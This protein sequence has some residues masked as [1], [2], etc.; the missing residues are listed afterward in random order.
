MSKGSST[1]RHPRLRLKC[2]RNSGLV[3]ATLQ[4]GGLVSLGTLAVKGCGFAKQTNQFPLRSGSTYSGFLKP[5]AGMSR[6]DC[7]LFSNVDLSD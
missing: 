5:T 4:A 2:R 1:N 7:L 6:L 3:E